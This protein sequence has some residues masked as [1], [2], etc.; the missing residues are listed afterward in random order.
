MT[1]INTSIKG[2]NHELEDTNHCIQLGYK[3]CF[4]SIRTKWQ[5]IDYANLFDVV[6]N[7]PRREAGS[8]NYFISSKSNGHYSKQHVEELT[9]WAFERAQGEDIVELRDHHDGEWKFSRV[10]CNHKQGCKAKNKVW[11]KCPPKKACVHCGRKLKVVKCFESPFV[12]ISRVGTKS[13]ATWD[14]KVK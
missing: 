8:H 1:Q 14:E 6:A 7:M 2:R 12:R 10:D 11:K 3:I 9:A 4:R 13:I 5:R